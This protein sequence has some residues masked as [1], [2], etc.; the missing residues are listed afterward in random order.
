MSGTVWTIIGVVFV[1]IWIVLG[2]EAWRTPPPREED[3][4]I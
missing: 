3:D 4:D 2:I 1:I